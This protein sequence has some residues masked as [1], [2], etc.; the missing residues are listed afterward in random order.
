MLRVQF[1]VPS[2]LLFVFTLDAN[3]KGPQLST[4]MQTLLLDTLM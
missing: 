2:I 4:R 1:I 3:A